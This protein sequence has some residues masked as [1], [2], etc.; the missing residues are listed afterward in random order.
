MKLKL[1]EAIAHR[2]KVP[3][4]GQTLIW[5]TTTR[6]LLLRV[7]AN[8]ARSYCWGGRVKGR[9]RRITLGP[10]P[11]LSV[12][13][14]RNAA[15]DVASRVA[16]GEDPASD[17]AAERRMLTFGALASR[18]MTD[19]AE[20]H[21]RSAGDDRAMLRDVLFKQDDAPDRDPAPVPAT[22]KSRRLSDISRD[23]VR[24]L[25]AR[26]STDAPYRANRVL[27]LLRKMFNLAKTWDVFT[28]DNPVVGIIANK[29]RSRDRHL[30]PD[31]L[32]RVLASIDAEPDERWR[33]YFKLLLL[34]G[35]RKMEL[36]SA[37]W[38]DIDLTERTWRLPQTK[39]DRSHMLPLPE[40]ALIILESLPSREAGSWVFPSSASASGHLTE[41]KA[42]WGRIR[43]R[44][45]VS[46]VRVHDLRRTLG[47]YLAA[48]GYSLP[49]IGRVLNHTQPST[50]AVYAR[51]DLEPVRAALEANSRLMLGEGPA[52]GS[53][54]GHVLAGAGDV[55]RG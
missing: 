6:G 7:T 46:D 43:Q 29:E 47:S 11:A 54:D 42:V 24:Q 41:A 50:T 14:A 10:S 20:R 22:W 8:G 12:P 15:L 34:L 35:P 2:T 16:R 44:A 51:L 9:V 40:H 49:L 19:H 30:S 28:G 53:P 5:D 21:K 25:H 3:P 48:S 55:L 36:L 17:R 37:K 1:T 33:S 23:D 31:E 26:I 38:A 39:A 45:N 18:Y 13:Q 4:T 52:A 27:A 32:K